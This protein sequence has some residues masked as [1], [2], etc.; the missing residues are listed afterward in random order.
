MKKKET[1]VSEWFDTK[2]IGIKIISCQIY[3]REN[4]TYIDIDTSQLKNLFGIPIIIEEE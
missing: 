1:F 2:S 4:D 3:D